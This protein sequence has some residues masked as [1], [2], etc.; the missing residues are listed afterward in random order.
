MLY[1]D[2][3]PYSECSRYDKDGLARRS[4]LLLNAE[5]TNPCAFLLRCILYYNFNT[6]TSSNLHGGSPDEEDKPHN[7][8]K[9]SEH[10]A[11]E[12]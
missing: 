11:R 3:S 7:E 1:S 5:K 4:V 10:G 2:I 8:P 6:E 9:T 12:S